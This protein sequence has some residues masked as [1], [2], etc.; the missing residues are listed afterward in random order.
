MGELI[1]GILWDEEKTVGWAW[2]YFAKN[3]EFKDEISQ[4]TLQGLCDIPT[5]E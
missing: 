4:E 1:P 2:C 5:L 3:V